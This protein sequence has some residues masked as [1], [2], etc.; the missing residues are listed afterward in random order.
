MMRSSL[1]RA[2]FFS[3]TTMKARNCT[4]MSALERLTAASDS[5]KSNRFSIK[6]QDLL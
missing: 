2:Q 4:C 3:H 1:E 5:L 6:I